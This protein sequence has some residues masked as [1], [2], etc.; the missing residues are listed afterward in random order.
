MNKIYSDAS[1]DPLT[2][3]GGYC[4]VIVAQDKKPDWYVAEHDSAG[5]QGTEAAGLREAIDI[6]RRLSLSNTYQSVV[7]CDNLSAIEQLKHYA[8]NAGVSLRH[9][10]AHT[11][12]QAS[13]VLTDDIKRQHWADIMAVSLVRERVKRL[14]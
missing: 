5:S 14:T 11:V 1:Y 9:V 8:S 13:T 3:V 12:S 6:G 7:F 2:K 10:K 4:I